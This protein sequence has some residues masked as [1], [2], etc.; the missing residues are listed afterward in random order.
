MAT[1]D[2][3]NELEKETFKLDQNAEPKLVTQLLKLLDDPA[4]NVQENAVKCL[5]LIMWR[6][7][8]AQASEIV[9]TLCGHMLN[10]KK[11]ELREIS[12]IGLHTVIVQLPTEPVNIPNL[13]VK[14]LTPRLI[15]GV[16]TCEKPEVKMC[17]LDIL[18]DMLKRFGS[19]MLGELDKIQKAVLPQ[20]TAGRPATRK[21]AIGCLGHIAVLVPDSLFVSL[22][23]F[24]ISN[25]EEA[26]KAENIRTLIQAIGAVSTSAGYRLGK[27]LPQIV[28]T[29]V[30]YCDS[31]KF[32]ND[33]ELRENCFQA[34]ESLVLKCPKDISAFLPDII[35]LALKYIKH[36]PN[37][38]EEADEDV[39]DMEDEGEEQ[40]EEEEA[41]GDISDDDD[42]SWKVRRSA[43]KCL[44]A[45]ITTRPERMPE[46]YAKVAP[47]LIARFREREENVK[48]DIFSTFVDVLKQTSV[49]TKR[50]TDANNL[51]PALQELT[52]KIVAGLT[53]ELSQK[54]AKTRAGAFALLKE[55]VGVRHG[56]LTNHIATIVPGV[57]FSLGDKGTNSNLKIEALTFLRLLLSSHPEDAF[58]PHMKILAPPIYK[59]VGDHYYRVSAEG[60]RVLNEFVKAVRPEGTTFDFHPYVKDIYNACV[61]QLKAQDIDQE[62]KECAITC[63][64]MILAT[65]GDDLSA[66]LPASLGLLLDKLRNEITRIFA[67][68]ALSRIATS[69][70]NIDITPILA[71]SLKELASFLRKNNRQLKQSSL[72][73]LD[74]IV[75]KYGSNK[76][77]KDLF[78]ATLA[79]VAPLI[80]DADLHLSHL[81]LQLCVS[82]LKVNP[83]SAPTIVEKILPQTQQLLR[84][85]L[86]QGLALESLL[87]L[88]AELVTSN[89]KQASFDTL[90]E[91][92]ISIVS[93]KGE[94]LSKQS[95]SSIAQTIA[96]ITA[97]APADKRSATVER[98]TKEVSSSKDDSL[99]LLC[100]LSLG[101]VG[102]RVDTNNSNLLNVVTSSFEST[103]EEIK[104]AASFALGNIS[105]GNLPKYMPFVLNEI[106]TQPKRQYLLLHSLREIIVREAAT[107]TGASILQP[108]L[109]P[110]LALLFENCESE[111]E[112]TRNV[113]AEC[114]GKLALISP[115]QL[116]PLLKER[117]TSP[118][119]HARSTVITALKY[120]ILEQPQPIDA[121]LKPA[122]PNFL[123]L[124]KD[125]ELNVRR[126]TLLTFNYAAH[127]KPGLIREILPEY[128]PTLFSES[129]VK[130]ELIREVDLGPFKHKVDDG[131]EIRKASYE[132]MY[133][134]L[135]SCLDRLELST[136]IANLNDGLK[137]NVDIK[138]LCHLMLIRLAQYAP[139]AL[140]EGLPLLV[141]SL[142][143]TVQTKVSEGAVKQQVERNEE[144]IRSALRSIAAAAKLPNVE[145]ATKFDEFLKQIV[146]VSPLAEKYAQIVA[147]ESSS[148]V[149]DE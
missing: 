18:N 7:K 51:L 67:V 45:I 98:F 20:L 91:S 19:L 113:V 11:D 79:E 117:V 131:L 46:I 138:M 49:L 62:V 96:S 100:L 133:T 41:D 24:L 108:Y 139:V 9:D 25:I 136:F 83:E 148:H 114:L 47:V 75:K 58:H 43:T 109:T 125:T 81:A 64:G 132:C 94:A 146:L 15:T 59:A 70:L 31:P 105:V 84:S 127:N 4:N 116:V 143:I 104:Q 8:D 135:D 145:S 35:T 63:I 129:K 1:H 130:P 103:S 82:I 37:Y 78:P 110:I 126:V 32:E 72:Q 88:Y 90:L 6:V 71:D 50:G 40:Q 12:N 147:E 120:T 140:V 3:A 48:L 80:S 17:C 128:M 38:A 56:L 73:A 21:R 30:K 54:S 141:D 34:F 102:R 69:R 55:L 112:G 65:L 107:G 10:E 74:D 101:E 86:L 99:R 5:G 142:R 121:L 26:K 68:K 123:S 144:M 39:E 13:I 93:K 22:I 27:Y 134:L 28:P 76:A 97:S 122:M 36:D 124:L 57:I 115:E 44:S 149:S 87:T 23:E 85:S 14:R 42:M 16:T 33:D 89:A 92:L 111:E 53:K 29:I 77:A 61:G 119:T 118:S 60:L 137:D 66:E 106:K 95:F 52:P 2:L